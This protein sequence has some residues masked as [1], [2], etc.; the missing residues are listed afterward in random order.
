MVAAAGW[1]DG[2]IIRKEQMETGLRNTAQMSKQKVKQLFEKGVK[3]HGK[4]QGKQEQADTWRI[5]NSRVSKMNALL[6][7][8]EEHQ[9]QHKI[10]KFS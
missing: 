9:I 1:M 3:R 7:M 2:W 4:G 5:T 10:R 6:A 8:G